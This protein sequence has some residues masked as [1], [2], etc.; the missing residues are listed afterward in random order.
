MTGDGIFSGDLLIVSKAVEV[1][2]GDII[3]VILNGDFVCNEI[4]I[5][6]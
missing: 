3:A 4:A 5:K 2:N 6:R 1:R